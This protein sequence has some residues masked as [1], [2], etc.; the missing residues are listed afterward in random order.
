LDVVRPLA[1][2]GRLPHL[3]RW[4]RDGEASPLASTVP[5]MSFP[6]WSS[7]ATGLAPG[8]HGIFDFTQKLPGAYRLRFVNAADRR[9]ETLFARAS[10]AGARVLCLGVPATYPPEPVRGLLVSGFD[11][12]VS[13]GT[14]DRHAS[15]P[16]LYRAVAARAGPWMTADL[17]EAAQGE[18]WH[19]R[20]SEVLLAR[21]ERKTA[22]AIEAL[23][24]VRAA[25]PDAEAELTCV[26]F[27]ESDT[28]AH[29][30]WRDFDP[31]SPRH[32]PRASAARRDALPA[33]YARLDTACARLREAAGEDALCLVLSDHGAGG[34]SHRI[35]HLGRR[36]AECGLL[37][38]A[39]VRRGP[40]LDV[41]ARAARDVALRVLPARLAEAAFRRARGAAARVESAVRFGG[42]DWAR[43][44]AF[45]EDVN[46]QPGVWINLRGREAEG[47]VAPADYER[48][49]QD[50][51]DA[52]LDWKLPGGG[53]IVARA[54]RREEVYAGPCADRAP[55]V[56]VELALDGGY[57]LSA[58]PTPWSSGAG[59]SVRALAP[60]EWAGGR[61]RGMNGT[62]RP[63]G[64]ALAADARSAEAFGLTRSGAGGGKPSLVDVA[65][66]VLR[67]LGVGTERPTTGPG[68]PGPEARAPAPYDD[69]DEALVAERLRGLGYLD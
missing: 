58:V 50:A 53:P 41:A 25:H 16:A 9:G 44:S 68:A 23:G 35:V 28:V 43:T 31:A 7:F 62:H 48:A 56:V 66:A 36:L 45:T 3:A 33:V 40:G 24:A 46:T 60:E 49:R 1:A 30:Y 69:A 20:A 15:D 64:I 57:G 32:D 38:R 29:H 63:D 2:A 59:P 4:L 22:F 18:G 13:R 51:I 21:I 61:G 17:D 19:E 65:P 54:R 52:L 39:P 5:P 26:V 12:P 10:R 42:I 11:A 47:S 14:D 8:D 34:A 55:D 37:R 6:A 67:A 27:S